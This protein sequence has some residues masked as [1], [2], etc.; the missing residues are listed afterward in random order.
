M[1]IKSFSIGGK[2]HPNEDRLAVRS[3]GIYGIAAVL[4]DG[5]GGLSLGNI[6][7]DVIIQSIARFLED[8]YKGNSEQQFLHKALEYADRELRHVSIKN[9]SNMGATVAAAI[10]RDKQLYYTWQ[11]NVRIYVQHEGEIKLLTVDHVADIG[12]GKTAL[13]RCLKGTGLRD[14]VPHRCHQLTTGD[15]IFICTDGLYRT[16]EEDMGI[17][18]IDEIKEKMG[19]PEDDASIIQITVE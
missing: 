3:I 1:K 9:K 16:A 17:I 11:G 7:A 6:A 4:A 14:D 12:Y 10:V 5:I 15:T 19:I 18:S 2:D 8:N 13:T